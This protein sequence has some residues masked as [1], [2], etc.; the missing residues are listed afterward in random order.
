MRRVHLV[1]LRNLVDFVAMA[2]LDELSDLLAKAK[3]VAGG[4]DDHWLLRASELSETI[5]RAVL[6]SPERLAAVQEAVQEAAA[7]AGCDLILGASDAADQVVRG[8]TA[9]GSEPSRA[10]LFDLVRVTGVAL[11]RAS[12]E[13]GHIDVVPAVLVDL[14]PRDDGR[15]P[16]SIVLREPIRS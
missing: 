12:A 10:L 4:H 5:N 15:C 16:R 6:S 3:A 13:V 11:A 1:I 7:D 8:L 14:R 9:D 2:P